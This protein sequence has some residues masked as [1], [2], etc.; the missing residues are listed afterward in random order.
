VGQIFHALTGLVLGLSACYF[1]G[2][3]LLG[4]RASRA[5]AARLSSQAAAVYERPEAS[6]EVRGADGSAR[7]RFHV[8]YLVPCLDEELVIGATVSLL[9]PAADPQ[10]IVVIDD[11]SSDGTGATARL[12]GG[13][14]VAVVR[15]DLPMARQGKGPA[16]NAGLLEVRRMVHERSQDPARVIVV[17]MDADGRLS[18]GA[19]SVVLPLFDGA[20]VGGAQLA[21]RIRNRGSWVTSFQDFQ[22]WTM[23]AMTQLGRVRTGTVSLGGNGQFTRL[24]ALLSIGEQPWDQSLTEDLDLTISL[25]VRGWR[26]TSTPHA[27]VDQQGVETAR[28]LLHQRT[29]WY[30]GHM[31]AGKRIPD[32]WRSPRIGHSSAVETIMYLLV[33]WVLDLPWSVLYHLALLQL[34][35]AVAGNHFAG[36]ALSPLGL[37]LLYVVA[38]YPALITAVLCR[39]RDPEIGW[40]RCVALGHSFLAMNYLSWACC[41]RALLR[42]VKGDTGWVKTARVAEGGPD[43]RRPPSITLVDPPVAGATRQAA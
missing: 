2:M 7:D 22:F 35:V 23:S 19:L 20:D 3:V 28:R 25:I 13:T 10:S 16:L 33:P 37:V 12:A 38:F 26:T 34:V 17:V 42:M 31:T 24:S 4:W 30:Q 5:G 6:L 41:W 32:I 15:R 21:V 8:Y 18:E 9:A 14:A 11:G 1:F 40:V 36:G 27:S 39:R 43:A 29:R